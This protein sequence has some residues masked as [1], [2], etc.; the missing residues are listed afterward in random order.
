[1]LVRVKGKGSI[2]GVLDSELA[3]QPAS[4]PS[5]RP[6][7]PKTAGLCNAFELRWGGLI[8][9]VVAHEFLGPGMARGEG[10]GRL[11]E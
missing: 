7:E 4:I 5:S 1:L 10:I 8:R 6:G 11:D 9:I 3:V 2:P